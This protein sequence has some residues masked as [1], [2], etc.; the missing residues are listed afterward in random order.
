MKPHSFRTA[1]LVGL[2]YLF[3]KKKHNII[4]VISIVSMVGI[5]VSTAAL[6]VVLSVFNGMEGFVQQCFNSFNPD[7]QITPKEG[8]SFERDTLQ[9][10]KLQLLPE[11]KSVYEVVSDL[12]LMTYDERQ[13]LVTLKGVED[14]YLSETK[15]DTLLIDGNADLKYADAYNAA[16]LG[17]IVAGNIQL[18]LRSPEML[19]FYYPKRLKKNLSDPATAFNTDMILASGVFASYTDYD[20]KIVFV[21][22][23]FARQIMD[24]DGLLTSVEVQVKKNQLNQKTQKKIQEVVGADF[25]VKNKYQQEDMLYKTMKSEKLMVF[26]ILAFILFVAAF[27]I[28]GTLGMLIIEKKNDIGTFYAMGARKSLVKLI[29]CVQGSCVSL[30]GGL[31]GLVLGFIVCLLQQVFH[32]VKLGGGEGYLLDYY[33]VQMN[34]VDFV[35]VL[36]TVLIISFITSMIPTRHLRDVVSKAQ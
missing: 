14:D 20:S 31:S 11:V 7:Y 6:I 30:L 12:T 28:I 9:I 19:K 15:M 25:E 34:P 3:S 8:K 18:N 4:N 24:Y 27:N 35:L 26:I 23:D 17:A 32:I 16:V 33:P 21:P 13:V 29:F 1:F 2:R 36:L 22:I 10:E 5:G